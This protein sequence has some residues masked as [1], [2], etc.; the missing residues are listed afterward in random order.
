M[1][2]LWRASTPSYFLAEVGLILFIL[3][4]STMYISRRWGSWIKRK[5][6]ILEWGGTFLTI[7]MCNWAHPFRCVIFFF[8]VR[9][10]VPFISTSFLY[11][12]WGIIGSLS[13]WL[14]IRGAILL[15]RRFILRRE[16]LRR[17][18]FGG[19]LLIF[20]ILESVR[21]VAR[22]VTLGGRL[23]INIIVGTLLLSVS[24]SLP[25]IIVAVIL[26]EAAVAFLQSHVFVSLLTLYT[27]EIY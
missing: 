2:Y 21:W 23:T 22:R 18:L 26:L 20:L 16:I 17:G 9:G 5:E 12:L 24:S 15:H 3:S 4:S 13:I 1:A 25:L 19:D 14:R 10:I 6:K 11:P 7:T 8:V 27:E